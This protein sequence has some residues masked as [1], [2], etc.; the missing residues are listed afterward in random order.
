[1]TFGEWLDFDSWHHWNYY[2][3]FPFLR[4]LNFDQR[5]LSTALRSQSSVLFRAEIQRDS[6]AS[7]RGDAETERICFLSLCLCV[8]VVQSYRRWG[9]RPQEYII[10]FRQGE[11]PRARKIIQNKVAPES[12]QNT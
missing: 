3:L 2:S 9:W 11:C 7:Y 12:I 8:S 6:Q 5:S 4:R 1:M 10:Y